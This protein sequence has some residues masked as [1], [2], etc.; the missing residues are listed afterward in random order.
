[1][2]TDV[3]ELKVP[4]Q[5]LS[6]KKY[7]EIMV[8]V[9]LFS[10]LFFILI[11]LACKSDQRTAELVDNPFPFI[12]IGANIAGIIYYIYNFISKKIM[13]DKYNLVMTIITLVV[14]NIALGFFTHSYL[15]T[16]LLDDLL[17]LFLAS[18]L[19]KYIISH[20]AILIINIKDSKVS[21]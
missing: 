21:L 3:K 20:L 19:L 7:V 17:L 2:D 4:Q 14:C 5:D 12:M 10:I 9:F 8:S 1:M 16:F 18:W 13:F 11:T 6:L 15:N